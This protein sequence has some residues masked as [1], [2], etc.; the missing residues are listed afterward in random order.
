NKTIEKPPLRVIKVNE[1]EKVLYNIYSDTMAGHFGLEFTF[2]RVRNKYF[3]PQMYKT[4]SDYIQTCNT[5]QQQDAPKHYEKLHPLRVATKYLTKW[6]KA[7]EIPD[8]TAPT[9]VYFIYEDIICHH[10]ATVLLD[11]QMQQRK[12]ISKLS[13]KNSLEQ[14][15]EKITE[16]LSQQQLVAQDN[17]KKTQE[18]QKDTI[19]KI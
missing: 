6:P 4:I 13:L 10:K 19:T 8:I 3:W 17:I 1:L 16:E 9:V 5:Y 18:K 7:H 11:L 2:N 15:I 12:G 14:H